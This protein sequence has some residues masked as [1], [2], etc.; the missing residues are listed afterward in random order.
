MINILSLR[1]LSDTFSIFILWE[2][3]IH[4]HSLL[5]FDDKLRYKSISP[6]SGIPCVTEVLQLY[7]VKTRVNYNF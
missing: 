3:I 5:R 1:A 6:V 4:T 2:T 7:I